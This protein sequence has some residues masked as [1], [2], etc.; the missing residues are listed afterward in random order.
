MAIAPPEPPRR[1]R[2]RRPAVRRPLWRRGRR[3]LVVATIAQRWTLTL[4]PGQTVVPQPLVTLRIKNGLKMTL[5]KRE[6]A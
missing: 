2:R 4:V 3:V 1:A 6:G 5:R